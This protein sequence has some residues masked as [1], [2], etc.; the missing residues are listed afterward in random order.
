MYLK[1]VIMHL[2]NVQC[3]PTKVLPIYKNV[4]HILKN[5]TCILYD[6]KGNPEKNPKK[7]DKKTQKKEKTHTHNLLKPV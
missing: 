5:S 3:V 7:G 1:N 6:K 4:Q 2:K